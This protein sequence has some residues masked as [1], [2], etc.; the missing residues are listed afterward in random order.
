M[1]TDMHSATLTLEPI[2]VLRCAQQ[3]KVDAPRQPAAA[4]GLGGV[5][6][7]LP[8]RNFEHALEDL[9]GWK[10][11]WV[12]FWFH[13]NTG[14]RP[15]VL[16][17]RSDSGRKGLFATRSPHRPNPL[18]LS[19]LRLDH[20]DGLDLHVR[21]VDLLD[22]TPVFDIKPYVPYTDAFPDAGSGWLAT[23]PRP[24]HTV[25]FCAEAE[26]QLA[27][28]A[29]GTAFPLRERIATAL[30]LGPVP[31]PYRR[32][33]KLQDG[34]SRLAVQDWRILFTTE[35]RDIHVQ[36]I[37]SGYKPAQLADGLDDPAGT[38]ALHRAF[39]VAWPIS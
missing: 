38:L 39:R 3:A 19:V 30:A 32:I 33:K 24:D 4:E 35:G 13:H 7:L 17:P 16:P 8:K 21:D 11:I 23:D 20:I 31:N 15:K 27:L 37:L 6:S 25:R 22:G 28:I 2:G 34:L 10:R 14:W 36:R 9:A 29:A 18:G 1:P 5:I 12:I 26:A